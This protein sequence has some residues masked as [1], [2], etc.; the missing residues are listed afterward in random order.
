MAKNVENKKKVQLKFEDDDD[1]ENKIDRQVSEEMKGQVDSEDWVQNTKNKPVQKISNKHDTEH[2]PKQ[3]N[4]SAR[5]K[6]QKK[7]S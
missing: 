5:Q 7:S 3:H 4:L 1:L 2:V 6:S